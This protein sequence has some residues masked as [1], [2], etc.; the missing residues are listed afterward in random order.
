MDEQFKELI[1]LLSTIH[2]FAS[3]SEDQLLAVADRLD[4]H[5][6]QENQTIFEK[7]DP[8]DG[9]YIISSGRVSIFSSSS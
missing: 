7:G 5:V 8:A 2:I 4:T 9:L 1:D 6:Y 3:L